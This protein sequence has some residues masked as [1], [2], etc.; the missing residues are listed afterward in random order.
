MAGI[1]IEA[2]MTAVKSES[3]PCIVIEV[4]ELPVS[5]TVAVL[6]LRAQPASVHVVLLVAGVAVRGRR[7][8]IQPSRVAT[9]AARCA[10]LTEEGVLGVSIMIEG[11]HSPLLLIMTFLAFRPKVGS[12]HV[13][14]FMA[15]I[16]VGRCF[17]AVECA[18]VA[19]AARSLLVITL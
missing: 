2:S 14:F 3:G 16:A 6:A 11:N 19:S 1:A 17:V 4:P 5:Y 9:L 10:M 13:V 18:F 12:M 15:G 7:V 8:L